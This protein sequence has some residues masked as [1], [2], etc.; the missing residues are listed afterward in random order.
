MNVL[1]VIPGKAERAHA[2]LKFNV[3]AKAPKNK[4][5]FHLQLTA[6]IHSI[7]VSK[8][9]PNNWGLECLKFSLH[10]APR[11]KIVRILGN[12]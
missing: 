3:W 1:L 2:I 10:L 4:S 11:Q 7:S 5:C 12:A 8:I 6:V 9:F